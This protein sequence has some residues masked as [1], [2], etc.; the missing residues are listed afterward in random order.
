LAESAEGTGE[1]TNANII[2]SGN[3]YPDAASGTGTATDGSV[4]IEANIE[5]AEGTGEAADATVSTST[6]VFVNAE[7]AS[8]TGTAAQPQV[9]TTGNVVLHPGVIVKRLRRP[10]VKAYAQAASGVGSATD[11]M[12]GIAPLIEAAQGIGVALDAGGTWN[13]DETVI[14]LAA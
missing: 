6:D 2:E 8:G 7:A 3:A 12:V 14:A 11:G 9:V 4:A 10:N 1:A 5:A 13:D